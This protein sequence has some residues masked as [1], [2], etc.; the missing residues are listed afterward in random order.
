MERSGTAAPPADAE[1]A[2]P[3]DSRTRVELVRIVARR[4]AEVEE[5]ETMCR[6][7]QEASQEAFREF[8][9]QITAADERAN[10]ATV[11]RTT[12]VA[13]HRKDG[14]R[15]KKQSAALAAEH[16]RALVR[17]AARRGERENERL[18]DVRK[19]INDLKSKVA[20]LEGSAAASP[21]NAA[22]AAAPLGGAPAPLPAAAAEE[23][24]RARADSNA[25]AERARV[26]DGD[27]AELRDQLNNAMRGA[28]S[29]AAEKAALEET[30]AALREELDVA[31][32]SIPIY[33]YILC[34]FY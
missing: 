34:E 33:R 9:E 26:L 12:L 31:C 20:R 29:A 30:V 32:V 25:H 1:D 21:A 14:E 13:A 17:E 7:V 16:A 19:Q 6:D 22:G 4:D 10:A 2:A 11:A 8:R 24:V 23:L 5:L 3:A 18:L 28:Y 15:W 27:L